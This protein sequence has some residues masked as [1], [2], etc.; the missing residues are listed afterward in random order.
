MWGWIAA[1]VVGTIVFLWERGRAA[2]APYVETSRG[3]AF[4]PEVGAAI[5]AALPQ[6]AVT[7][8][9]V[10]PG[11]FAIAKM[12]NPPGITAATLFQQSVGTD[13]WIEGRI[14]DA[15]ATFIPST[16]PI[17]LQFTAPGVL[18]GSTLIE[19]QGTNPKPAGSV[20]DVIK[21]PR[22]LVLLSVA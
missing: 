15:M 3:V 21:D 7:V 14:L 4:K 19:Q 20:S 6:F 5:I 18:P 11:T 8:T 17:V 9:G 22:R 2:S 1:G 16:S 13:V 12:Q 10:L